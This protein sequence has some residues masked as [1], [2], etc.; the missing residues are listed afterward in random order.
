MR[1]SSASEALACRLHHQTHRSVPRTQGGHFFRGQDACIGVGQH[2]AFKGHLAGLEN[3]L[4]GI[5]KAALAEPFAVASV[6]DFGLISQA[7]KGLGAARGHTAA[8][9]IRHLFKRVGVGFRR[10]RRFGVTA[11][12]A[13]IAAEVRQR[14]KDIPR[15]GHNVALGGPLAFKRRLSENRQ[16]RGVS[17]AAGEPERFPPSQATRVQR[18]VHDAGGFSRG[19]RFAGVEESHRQA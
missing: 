8:H 17:K 16:D 15:D 14:D 7:Q 9:H 2:A 18:V 5:A 11:V 12:R 6:S 1:H 4:R 3:Q 13:A 10:I 19:E